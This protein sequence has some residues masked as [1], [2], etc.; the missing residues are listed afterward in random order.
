MFSSRLQTLDCS[1][2]YIFDG[3]CN[4]RNLLWK[5]NIC[6]SFTFCIVECRMHFS[7]VKVMESI[8]LAPSSLNTLLCSYCVILLTLRFDKYPLPVLAMCYILFTHLYAPF[9]TRPCSTFSYYSLAL[10]GRLSVG[11]SVSEGLPRRLCGGQATLLCHPG[12]AAGNSHWHLCGTKLSSAQHWKDR[13]RLYEQLEKRTKINIAGLP[14]DA[15][16]TRERKTVAA[17]GSWRTSPSRLDYGY[18]DITGISLGTQ[19]KELVFSFTALVRVQPSS[20][21]FLLS[22]WC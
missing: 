18:N 19:S 12:S 17:V 15:T 5:N 4:F 8:C 2:K 13:E 16:G 1:L 11:I 3:E 22:V 14:S 7:S 21:S 6:P 20:V 10:A 9:L